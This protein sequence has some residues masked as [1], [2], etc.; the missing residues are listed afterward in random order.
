MKWERSLEQAF[1][2]MQNLVGD[3]LRCLDA[4]VGNEISQYL[5][6]C[7]NK[8]IGFV[9]DVADNSFDDERE[10]LMPMYYEI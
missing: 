1:K 9:V 5:V 7:H 10:L 8:D 3:A 6:D 4:N 2:F